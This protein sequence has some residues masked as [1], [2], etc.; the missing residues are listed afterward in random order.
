MRAAGLALLLAT[1]LAGGASAESYGLKAARAALSGKSQAVIVGVPRQFFRQDSATAPT[2]AETAG[3]W[4]Y[5]FSEWLGRYRDRTNVVIVDDR[6]LKQLLRSP[7][8]TRTCTTLF[9]RDPSHA[10]VYDADCVPQ[11]A[12]YDAGATWVQTGLAPDAKLGLR[13][14][15]LKLR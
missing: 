1:A 5:Y 9:V 12:V 11:A 10:L 13:T 2:E 3:D 4:S 8:P 14:V 6:E 15:D 7:A